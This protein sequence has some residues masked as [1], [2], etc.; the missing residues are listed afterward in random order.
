MAAKHHAWWF[1]QLSMMP[2]Y[3][4]VRGSIGSW[5]RVVNPRANRQQ[6][7][8]LHLRQ[9]V[10]HIIARERTRH[11]QFELSGRNERVESARIKGPL[12]VGTFWFYESNM[13]DR[14]LRTIANA[15]PVRSYTFESTPE[16][17]ITGITELGLSR[18]SR[19]GKS[20]KQ[21]GRTSY[22]VQSAF[23]S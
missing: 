17:L 23:A 12:T 10:A 8:K 22:G 11:F 16:N 9:A 2:N 19:L 14:R 3:M 6:H 21:A 5:G 13:N 7:R 1:K 4:N 15:G 20:M 18:K